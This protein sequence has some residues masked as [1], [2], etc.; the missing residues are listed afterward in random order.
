MSTTLLESDDMRFLILCA[1]AVLILT[2][3]CLILRRIGK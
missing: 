3:D 2:L 1:I